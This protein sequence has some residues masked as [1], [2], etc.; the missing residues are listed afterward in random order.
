M[1]PYRT[2]SQVALLAF[3]L[4]LLAGCGS[5]G[6]T[7]GPS[8]GDT[9]GSHLVVFASDRGQSAGQ[10]DLYLYD[11]DAQGFRLIRGISSPTAPDLHPAITSD[12]LVIAFQS[13]R[14]AGTKSDILLYARSRQGLIPLTGVNTADDEIEPSFTFDALK[15]AFTRMSGATKRV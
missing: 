4:G 1:T 14:G 15:M 6:S 10:F 5:S 12:G 11:I 13:D 3:A 8:V 2:A 9:G 7:T